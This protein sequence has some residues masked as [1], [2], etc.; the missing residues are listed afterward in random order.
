[1]AQYKGRVQ[2]A[3]RRQQTYTQGKNAYVQGTAVRKPDERIYA[4][5][6]PKRQISNTARKNREKAYHMSF[7]YVLFLSCAVVAAGFILMSYIGLQS[8]LTNSIKNVSRL[9]KELNNL[10]LDNDEEYNR[11]TSS[12]DMEEVKR[13]AIQ[14]LGMKYAEEG[15]IITFSGEGSDYVRQVADIPK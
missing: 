11:I 5:R 7:G 13:I 4:P 14:E 1:M 2:N 12:I 10:K 3:G 9:E 6:E 8:D 15:Q